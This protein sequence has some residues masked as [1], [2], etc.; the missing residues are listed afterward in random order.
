MLIEKYCTPFIFIAG[1]GFFVLAFITMCVI[2][3]IQ[4]RITDSTITNINEEEVSVPDYTEL[5]KR[6]MRVYINEAC[7]QCH[8]QFIR[9]VAGE[10]KRWGPISQAGEKSWDKPHLFGTRR[11]GPDLSREGGTRTDGWHYAHLYSPRSVM[12]DSVMPSFSWLFKKDK[13]GNPLPSDDVSA[14]VSYLQK[15]GTAIGDWSL[16]RR[17]NRPSVGNPPLVTMALINRGKDVF[18]RYCIGCHGKEGQGDG[19]MA[20]F[21]EF[22]PRDFTKG[23]FRIGSTFDLPTEKDI[24]RTITRGMYGSAMPS[25]SILSEDD[26]WALVKFI[27]TLA[28]FYD[29]DEEEYF[30]IFELRG[31]SPEVYISAEPEVT[32]ESIKRGENIFKNVI[33]CPKCHGEDNKGLTREDGDFDWVDEAGRPIP[34][35]ADLTSGVFKSGSSPQDIYLI[36]V[37]GREGSPMPSFSEK[38]PSEQDRWDLVHYVRSLFTDDLRRKEVSLLPEEYQE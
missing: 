3:S 7:W 16:R 1:I 22:K 32:P 15:L 6:G 23:V 8:T 29:E 18:M 30:N 37:T 28:I 17:E 31:E 27:K 10:E 19:E 24:F 34:K 20:I 36:F 4:V 33:G 2:P 9:P 14:L 13:E 25:W 21:F 26:R 35:S 11:V 38:L 12:S 5:Q